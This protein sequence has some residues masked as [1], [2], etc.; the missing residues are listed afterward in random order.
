M[1]FFTKLEDCAAEQ[2]SGGDKPFETG[3][4]II[5]ASNFLNNS[6]QTAIDKNN[7]LFFKFLIDT[8][9]SKGLGKFSAPGQQGKF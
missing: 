9:Q 4:G 6:S 7:E 3:T 1:E 2:I 8:P 5:T